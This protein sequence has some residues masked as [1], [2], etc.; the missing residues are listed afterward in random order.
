LFSR[1]SEE[2][3]KENIDNALL[4]E[5]H[6]VKFFVLSVK[7]LINEGNVNLLLEGQIDKSRMR[8]MSEE[9]ENTD[10]KDDLTEGQKAKLEGKTLV[11]THSSFSYAAQTY[12]TEATL[13]GYI[14]SKQSVIIYARGGYS[15]SLIN[16][17]SY[18]SINSNIHLL[19]CPAEAY[20]R[21]I[22]VEGVKT[23]RE[24]CYIIK[25]GDITMT[26]FGKKL[27]TRTADMVRALGLKGYYQNDDTVLRRIVADSR[28]I[29][30]DIELK[31]KRVAN[32]V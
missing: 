14:A 22:K 30:T 18:H 29:N 9:N 1:Y 23:L 28:G 6:I 12:V 21:F 10:K 25:E 3:T 11:Y 8:D 4:K 17:A 31:R 7:K 15:S 20:K 26:S 5:K 2:P 13:K 16:D 19:S 24:A 32:N 27:F